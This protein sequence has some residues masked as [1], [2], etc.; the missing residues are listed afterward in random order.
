MTTKEVR[1]TFV[2]V[3]AWLFIIFSGFGALVIALE[4]AFFQFIFNSEQMQ[5]T[6]ANAANSSHFDT[7]IFMAILHGILGFLLLLSIVMLASSIGLLKRKNW[8]RVFFIV[9]LVIGIIWNLL[10]AIGQILITLLLHLGLHDAPPET[11]NVASVFTV[12]SVIGVVF[13]IGFCVLFGWII[14]RLRTPAIV[15][16]F[17]PQPDGSAP[18]ISQ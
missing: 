17:K 3:L 2:D 16:E 14:K 18:L 1:S 7:S 13:A 12:A 10:G 6:F 9:M 8:A 4:I 15:A 5:Q 11:A